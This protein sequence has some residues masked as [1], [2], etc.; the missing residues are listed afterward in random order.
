MSGFVSRKSRILTTWP[1]T[2]LESPAVG[3]M[4]SNDHGHTAWGA[5]SSSCFTDKLGNLPKKVEPSR[6]RRLAHDPPRYFTVTS[7]SDN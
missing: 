7:M 2:I 1:P 5:L 4:K 3:D 6:D